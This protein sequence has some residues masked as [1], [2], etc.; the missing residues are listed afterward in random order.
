MGVNGNYMTLP[1]VRALAAVPRTANGR[2]RNAGWIFA[3]AFLTH[4]EGLTDSDGRF[5]ADTEIL[6]YDKAGAGGTLFGHPFRTTAQLRI[7]EATGTN[8]DTTTVIFSSDWDATIIGFNEDVSWEL[9]AINPAK[10]GVDIPVPVRREQ[11]PFES[12]EDLRLLARALGPRYGPMILF[13]AATGLRPGEWTAL[14]HRDIDLIAGV[15]LV[16][17]AYRN[18]RLKTLKTP[19][20]IRAVP[21][22]RIR[23]RDARAR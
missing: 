19:G 16:K 22:Q 2:Y 21:L 18:R 8:I 4:L 5:L 6:T 15:V 12:W 10:V 9:N 20:S 3:P 17:R 23:D 7:N 13:A 14:E 11:R 1:Q